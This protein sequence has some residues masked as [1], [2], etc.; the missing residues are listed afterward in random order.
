MLPKL[1]FVI[2]LIFVTTPWASPPVALALGL[3]FGLT[4]AHPF[5]NQAHKV[6]QILLQVSVVGLG[7]SMNLR[8]VVKVGRSG[9]VYTLLSICFVVIFGLAL[10]SLL[11]VNRTSSFLIAV[12][13]AICGG[14][15]IAAVGPIVEATNEDMSVSLGTVFILNSVANSCLHQIS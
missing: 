9:F 13:T 4:L 15:A 11:R 10:G 6:S 3:V 14:S 7:F 12:G 1:L 5:Q 2:G 8:D